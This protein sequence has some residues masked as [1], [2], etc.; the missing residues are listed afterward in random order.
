ML[1][2]ESASVP[3]TNAVNGS[4]GQGNLP[5]AVAAAE[6]NI[7]V[8]NVKRMLGSSTVTGVKSLLSDNQKQ[9]IF[10]L[11][12]FWSYH[13][14]ISTRLAAFKAFGRCY[15][16][17]EVLLVIRLSSFLTAVSSRQ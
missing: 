2:E 15:K 3:T 9:D 11:T 5:N 12:C 10:D 14:F 1:G 8:R 17:F 7:A 13:E 6:R 16:G 4:S